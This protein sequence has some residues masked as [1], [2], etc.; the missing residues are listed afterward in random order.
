L[1]LESGAEGGAPFRPAGRFGVNAI[2]PYLVFE[3]LRDMIRGRPWATW[4]RSRLSLGISRRSTRHR[5]GDVQDGHL[6]HPE[7]PGAQIFEAIGLHPSLVQRFFTWTA[8]RVGGIGLSE[9]A[10]DG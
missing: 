10:G 6:H 3:T 2:N 9:V 7:L 1:V 5:E 4:T 8:S